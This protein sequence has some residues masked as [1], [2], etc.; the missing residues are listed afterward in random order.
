MLFHKRAIQTV[1]PEDVD[2]ILDMG[3]KIFDGKNALRQKL[4]FFLMLLF[5]C[6]YG[7]D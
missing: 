2:S 4:F 5:L 3:H 1:E 7:R 6:E